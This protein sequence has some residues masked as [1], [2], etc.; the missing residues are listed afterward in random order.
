MKTWLFSEVFSWEEL[1]FNI[2]RVLKYIGGGTACTI[3]RTWAIPKMRNLIKQMGLEV[4]TVVNPD[5]LLLKDLSQKTFNVFHVPEAENNDYIP[6][7][8]EFVKS[9]AVKSVLGFGGILPFGNVSM[10][11]VF[12]KSPI[13][14]EAASMFNTLALNVK[15]LILPFEDSIF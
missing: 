5:P 15:L 8:D 4:E 11:I 12:S 13:S 10:V 3:L 14:V 2:C 7:Q 6:A 9:Y 1:F